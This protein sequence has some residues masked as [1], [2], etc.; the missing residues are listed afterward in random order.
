MSFLANQ[1]YFAFKSFMKLY[2][3]SMP[4][5][6][7]K[8]SL[9]DIDWGWR[10]GPAL[11]G[12]ILSLTLRIID[13]VLLLLLILLQAWTEFF[14]QLLWTHSDFK[15]V[16]RHTL[17]TCP[18]SCIYYLILDYLLNVIPFLDCRYLCILRHILIQIRWRSRYEYFLLL[19]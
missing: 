5:R 16:V 6:L 15:L 12:C 11:R 3:S 2:Y 4:L 10:C 18:T 13:C 8:L 17:L 7:G 9:R 1:L 14:S 19:F